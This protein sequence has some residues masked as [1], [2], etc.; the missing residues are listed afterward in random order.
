MGLGPRCSPKGDRQ[1]YVIN[2]HRRG[3]ARPKIYMSGFSEGVNIPPGMVQTLVGCRLTLTVY[4]DVKMRN[5]V[6]NDQYIEV[7]TGL[8]MTH[9]HCLRFQSG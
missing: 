5:S 8:V 9:C 7:A 2:R 4:P 1:E 3:A 6:L